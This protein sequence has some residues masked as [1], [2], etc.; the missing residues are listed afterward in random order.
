M[1]PSAASSMPSAR[2]TTWRVRPAGG[3]RV[4]QREKWYLTFVDCV[5]HCEDTNLLRH[6]YAPIVVVVVASCAIRLPVER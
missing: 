1:S 3:L 5:A 2:S 4:K 6:G